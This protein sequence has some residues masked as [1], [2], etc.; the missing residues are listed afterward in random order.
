M[1]GLPPRVICAMSLGVLEYNNGTQGWLNKPL[2]QCL[3][4]K[5]PGQV[6]G[7]ASA[8]AYTSP[9]SCAFCPDPFSHRTSHSASCADDLDGIS[10]RATTDARPYD[11]KSVAR[12]KILTR[13]DE[14]LDGGGVAR[15]I[16]E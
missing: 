4:M 7:E 9:S 10:T 15:M 16:N 8:V 2:V 3:L 1:T 13:I 14:F 11:H 5:N 6:D 12:K